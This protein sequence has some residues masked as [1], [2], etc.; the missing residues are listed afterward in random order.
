VHCLI[1]ATHLIQNSEPN[2]EIFAKLFDG[3]Q[4]ESILRLIHN[5]YVMTTLSHTDIEC[6]LGFDRV[7]EQNR[8]S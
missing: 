2:T 7:Q 5:S 1:D 6:R 4:D 3:N 8:C